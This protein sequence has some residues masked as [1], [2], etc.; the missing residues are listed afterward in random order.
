[1]DLVEWIKVNKL[2]VVWLD[3]DLFKIDDKLFF[4]HQSR[5]MTTD[6]GEERDL[7]I[8]HNF[9]FYYSPEQIEFLNDNLIDYVVFKFGN[10]FYYSTPFEVK[11]DLFKY[12]GRVDET[13]GMT[14]PFLG[15]HGGY[16]LGNGSKN[17]KDWIKKAKFLGC[18]T[19]GLCEENTLAGTLVF[20]GA[21]QKEKIKYIIGETITV[22][23]DNI[24]FNIKLFVIDE[25]GWQNLLRINNF[26]TSNTVDGY[27][28]KFIP[29]LEL[30]KHSER[31]VCVLTPDIELTEKVIQKFSVFKQLYFQLDFVAW[32]SNDRDYKW[33]M[34]LKLYFDNFIDLISPIL[35]SDAYYLDKEDSIIKKI[36]NKNLDTG[37]K[38]QSE[39]QYF[40][41]A[42]DIYI[43]MSVLFNQK[44][45]RVFSIFLQGIENLNKVTS[46]IN[47]TI[48]TG[49]LFL[50]QYE[51][52]IEEK[53]QFGTNKD[54]FMHLINLGFDKKIKG[55]VDNEQI[56]WDRLDVEIE[57]IE[58]GGFINYFLILFD[59]YR[60]CGEQGIYTGLGRGSASGSLVSFLL[61]LTGID[62]LKYGLLFERFLNDGR[63]K[64]EEVSE[65]IL[66]LEDGTE[67]VI[68]ETSIIKVNREGKIKTILGRELVEDDEIVLN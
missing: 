52:S 46:S 40:K 33:L 67:K 2:K 29:Y 8:D 32:K 27:I 10:F 25:I 57:I 42:E 28:Q 1:M 4:Y 34:N 31:L 39:D 60:Y 20:Q 37:F 26:I 49:N 50:P 7:I 56:Y 17:Y 3:D 14:M 44:D 51:M 48:K 13:L 5:K 16:E 19:L 65:L 53:E 41:S 62:P 6:K 23:D 18:D 15:I 63:Y 66:T 61:G 9:Q 64:N 38:P 22:L 35:I 43:Q 30:I 24:R 68:E 47:F 59:I 45:E 21:C 58:R 12:I 11:L 55:R 54:F 36:L